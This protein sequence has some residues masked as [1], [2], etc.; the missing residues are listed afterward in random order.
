MSRKTDIQVGATVL[1]ALGLLLW[2]IAWLS[3][4]ARAQMQRVWHVSFPE[5]GGLLEG[6]DA[7]VN[8]VRKGSV[9]SIR[10]AG[11]RVIVDVALS[12]DIELT[13][14]SRV[15]VR[16]FS[17][18]GDRIVEVT[19]RPTGRRYSTRDTIPGIYEKGLP[20]IMSDLGRATNGM[21]DIA[22]ELDSLAV[23]LARQ[24]GLARTVEDWRQMSNDLRE[25]V[26]ENRV[27]LHST[28]RNLSEASTSARGLLVDRHEDLDRTLDHFAR[29]A[30]NLDRLSVRL[31]SLRASAQTAADRLN[32]GQGTAGKLMND[33]KLYA[34]MRS[35]VRDLRTLIADIKANPHRYLKF[36]VF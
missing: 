4:I 20:D 27:A 2:G 16:S 8:G 28:L 25:A 23:A 18:M 35:S 34:E 17:M 3:S 22:I 9:R 11:D 33:E 5:G 12:N 14:D 32:S 6:N 13:S 29:A 15:A 24:G 36:S 21:A 30:E 1:V 10:L 26:A 19:Y 31:D 7:H